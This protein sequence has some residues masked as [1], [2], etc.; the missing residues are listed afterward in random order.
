MKN[1]KQ[2]KSEKEVSKSGV[3]FEDGLVGLKT[4]E[5]EVILPSIFDDIYKIS[6]DFPSKG[7]RLVVK[8]NGKWG[9]IEADGKGA[10]IINPEY[11]YIG[12][13]NRITHVRKDDK[14][15]VL[16]I[17]KDEY[18]IKPECDLIHDTDGFMFNNGIGVYE[19]NGRIGI[20][21]EYGNFTD[22]IFEDLDGDPDGLVEVKF[23]GEW[24][25]I[26]ENN[27]FTVDEEEAYYSYEL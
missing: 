20:V 1:K 24:G 21:T 19:K 13:P 14:W 10:W 4:E 25:F 2:T 6:P 22:A 15:G 7:D 3:I 5:G 9:V 8:Q 17:E 27:S 11:E 18:L 16:D 23:E 26:D 12:Y